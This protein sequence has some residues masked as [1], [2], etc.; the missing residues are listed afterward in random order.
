[1]K[2]QSITNA[3]IKSNLKN[4]KKTPNHSSQITHSSPYNNELGTLPSHYGLSFGGAYEINNRKKFIKSQQ[5]FTPESYK[6]WKKINAVADKFNHSIITHEHV[7]YTIL[8]DMYRFIESLDNGTKKYEDTT[9]YITPQAFSTIIGSYDTFQKEEIRKKI[10]PIIKKYMAIT[11]NSLRNSDIPKKG[12]RAPRLADSLIEDINTSYEAVKRLIGSNSFADNTFL[13]AVYSCDKKS[14]EKR[15]KEFTFEMQRAVMEDDKPAK[16]KNHLKIYDERADKLWKN[17][18]LGNDMYITYE[19]DN[20][21]SVAHLLSSFV[22]LI[23]KPGQKYNNLNADNTEIIIFNNRLIFEPLKKYIEMAK[24]D[25]SKTYIF[26]FNFA[27]ILIQ[28]S[29]VEEREALSL[30]QEEVELLANRNNPNIRFVLFSNKD[31][32]YANSTAPNSSVKKVLEQYDTLSIPMINAQGAKEILSSDE[33]LDY[34]NN[35]ISKTFDKDAIDLAVNIT[36]ERDGYYP[37]KAIEYLKKVASYYIDKEKISAKDVAAYEEETNDVRQADESQNEFQI[38][39]NTNKTLDDIVGSPMTKAEAQSIVNQILME[40]KGYI[41]GFTTF[42]DN[43]SSYGGGRKHTA[44]CIAGEAQIPMITINARDFALKDID[45]LNANANFSELK[46]R[47]LINTAKTQAEANKNKTV[48]IYIENFDNFGSNPLFGISS[49]YEQKAFSQ[50]LYE[51]ENLRKNKNINMIIVGSTNYPN[52][53]DENIMKPY[54]FLNKIIIYS[55]QDNKDRGNI[56]EYYINKNNL[57]VGRNEEEKAQIIKN[58]SETTAGFSV[59]DLIYILE[60]ADEISRERGK[61][62]IDKSDFTEAYLQT[63]TGRVSSRQN[64]PHDREVITSHEC[65]HALMMQVMYDIAQKENKP[66]HLPDKVNFITLDPRGDFGGAV[67]SK[68][69]ENDEYSF[70]KMFSTLVFAFGGHASE[71]KFYNMQGSWGITQDMQMATQIANL[72]VLKMGLGAKTGRISLGQNALGDINVSERLKNRIEED[73]ETML[74]NAELASDKIADA[75]GDFI[76]LFT[77]KYKSKVGSGDCIISSE[78]FNA[79]LNDWKEKQTP[80][81]LQELENLEKEILL[82]IAKTKKGEIVKE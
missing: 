38:T 46:I 1:M 73:V 69:A 7:F 30:T 23:K 67:Y 28:N 36:N 49:I 63:T 75:Y 78:E 17:L 65:G 44:Q 43:G 47:K 16:Q 79:I 48:M 52:A 34:I 21:E 13:A 81:K 59:V 50:L 24:K 35:F 62:A 70:E 5:E 60:K 58:I 37:E 31:V 41:K 6:T 39:F 72:A 32:Y 27:D 76:E 56:F 61:D 3:T 25:P 8:S 42:L 80:E 14:F 10:K 51:M 77:D 55:P 82:I 9:S 4:T 2:I 74:K 68:D 15:L 20:K 26:V 66:W 19:G 11:A 53:L 57:K 54:K 22:N 18:D 45:A 33:G 71:N 40:K 12:F 64:A 29:I